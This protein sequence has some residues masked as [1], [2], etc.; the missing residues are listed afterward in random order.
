[1]RSPIVNTR[2]IES[3]RRNILVT[4]APGC[5]T[6]TLG[7]A[8]AYTLK[9]PHFDTDDYEWEKTNPPF[10]KKTSLDVR[11]SL[12]NQITTGKGAVVSGSLS[13][14]TET[15]GHSLSLVVFLTVDTNTRLARLKERD[16]KLYGQC[17]IA[18]IDWAAG[19]DAGVRP[20]RSLQSHEQWLNALHCRVLRI[21]GLIPTGHQVE[22][23]CR[24]IAKTFQA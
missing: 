16:Y 13:G 6:S 10:V 21:S 24:A 19:Y 15:I 7:L 1:M 11:L 22:Q 2:R 4:G 23:I 3:Y 18:F 5:G 20:G 17:R 9:L 8:L 12:I 14:W